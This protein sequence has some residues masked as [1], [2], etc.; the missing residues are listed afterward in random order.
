MCLKE[1]WEKSQSKRPV[2]NMNEVNSQKLTKKIILICA[3]LVILILGV[4]VYALVDKSNPAPEPVVVQVVSQARVDELNNIKTITDNGVEKK[5]T[6]NTIIIKPVSTM[7]LLEIQNLMNQYGE[8]VVT[9]IGFGFYDVLFKGEID[10]TAKLSEIKDNEG[11]SSAD[12]NQVAHLQVTTP[13]DYSLLGDPYWLNN[14]NAKTAW[15]ITKGDPNI[16]V[17]VIDGKIYETHSDLLGKVQNV[18]SWPGAYAFDS[19]TGSHGTHVAGIIAAK[20]NNTQ[21][22]SAIGWNVG[23]VGADACDPTGTCDVSLII[24]ALN[25]ISVPATGVRVINMSFSLGEG[26]PPPTSALLGQALAAV[27]SNIVMIAAAGN[28]GGALEYPASDPNVLAVMAVDQSG[29]KAAFSASGSGAVNAPGVA[30]NSTIWGSPAY[31][32]KQGTS[33]A[34]P[35]VSGLAG[36]MLSAKSTLS[37]VDITTYITQTAGAGVIHAQNAVS[38]ASTGVVITPIPAVPTATPSPAGG[39]SVCGEWKE[40]AVFPGSVQSHQ[41]PSFA[42]GNMYYVLAREDTKIMYAKQNSNGSLSAWE[43]VD[44]GYAHGRS[45]KYGHPVI[46]VNG[47]NYEFVDGQDIRIDFSADGVPQSRTLVGGTDATPDLGGNCCWHNMW[48]TIAPATVGGKNLLYQLLY[49]GYSNSTQPGL[50][51]MDVT[52]GISGSNYQFHPLGGLPFDPYKSVFTNG[53]LYSGTMSGI[54]GPPSQQIQVLPV[55]GNGRPSGGWRIASSNVPSDGTGRGEMLVYN[56]YLYITRGTMFSRAHIEANGDLGVWESLP[57]LPADAYSPLA[58]GGQAEGGAYGI[59]NGWLYVTG[60]DKAYY[61]SLTGNC[62]TGGSGT[63]GSYQ[64][65]VGAGIACTIPEWLVNGPGVSLPDI[66][67]EEIIAPRYSDDYVPVPG[68]VL[69]PLPGPQCRMCSPKAAPQPL[70]VWVKYSPLG[71]DEGQKDG[72]AML[73][74]NRTYRYFDY[75]NGAYIDVP[76]Y[77][78]GTGGGTSGGDTSGNPP[79][80]PDLFTGAYSNVPCGWP[81]NQGYRIISSGCGPIGLTTQNDPLPYDYCPSDRQPASSAT[82][83]GRSPSDNPTGNDHTY[84]AMDIGGQF[85]IYS[86]IAGTLYRCIN[87]TSNQ[88]PRLTPASYGIYTIII[89]DTTPPQTPG[90]PFYK[91]LFGHLNPNPATDSRSP[92]VGGTNECAR[93]DTLVDRRT[94][95]RGESIGLSGN[96]GSSSGFHLHYEIRNGLT[97]AKIC[98]ASYIDNSNTYCTS[99]I[100]G[101]TVLSVQ[102]FLQSINP[103]SFNE[104]NSSDSQSLEI[105][106]NDSLD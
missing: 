85:P 38:A 58:W 60:I 4:L 3:V 20:T 91:L 54:Q 97:G 86:P 23:L 25:L 18:M 72:T 5:I 22:V 81:V 62:G 7:T 105:N 8:C 55:D 24:Q 53:Y 11:I 78:F 92:I 16:K 34:A 67:C 45:L 74:Q 15:D 93:G 33:M 35:I 102:S 44:V 80:N 13:D 101:A 48:H 21:G 9:E 10:I 68:E 106:P 39:G 31:G 100:A 49:V 2:N 36:L 29:N 103:F 30:I 70:P 14:I 65:G 84:A 19:D 71:L 40:T 87:M 95:V 12:Y 59:I 41:Q 89:G 26:D 94:I 73:K 83:T 77:W 63:G 1:K 37:R 43:T 79:A 52:G 88:D 50:Y 27:P 82:C 76:P 96:S 64:P 61:I 66:K 46:E 32:I 99:G 69:P 90:K 6:G 51:Y 28:G 57:N 104:N 56:N 75:D 47:D 98:P 17:G 42:R